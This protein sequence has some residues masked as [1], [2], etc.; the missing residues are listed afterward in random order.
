MTFLKNGAEVLATGHGVAWW[1]GISGTSPAD[2]R[3]VSGIV[4]PAM[5]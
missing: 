2:Q 3:K 1:L 4:D 5:H